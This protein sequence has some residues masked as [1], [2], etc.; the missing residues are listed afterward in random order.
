MLGRWSWQA[1]STPGDRRGK[2]QGKRIRNLDVNL[3]ELLRLVLGRK[4]SGVRRPAESGEQR[5]N[6]W[7][8]KSPQNMQLADRIVRGGK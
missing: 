1:G 2:G 4:A 5:R 7:A 3:R 6:D 8:W